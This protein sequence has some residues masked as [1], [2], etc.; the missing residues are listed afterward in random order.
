MRSRDAKGKYLPHAPFPGRIARSSPGIT[1]RWPRGASPSFAARP[2]RAP[3]AAVT[4]TTTRQRARRYLR[5]PGLVVPA[6]VSPYNLRL[7]S[8]SQGAIGFD[9][10]H[11]SVPQRA[12]TATGAERMAG[13][14]AHPRGRRLWLWV[15]GELALVALVSSRTQKPSPQTAATDA[16]GR[17][18]SAARSSLGLDALRPRES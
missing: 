7:L 2:E 4:P 16:Q 12:G 3:L 14:D 8:R 17:D 1:V 15:I 11:D 6:P 18:R 10:Q 9:L 13:A 5:A